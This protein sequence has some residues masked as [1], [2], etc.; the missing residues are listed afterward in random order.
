[1]HRVLGERLGTRHVPV[2]TPTTGQAIRPW[3][4]SACRMAAFSITGSSNPSASYNRSLKPSLE[5][6]QGTQTPSAIGNFHKS[7]RAPRHLNT[8]V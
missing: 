5:T 7:Q 2:S 4:C 3:L 6:N 1:M 8:N